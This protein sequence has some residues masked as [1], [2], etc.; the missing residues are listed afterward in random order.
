MYSHSLTHSRQ[1]SLESPYFLY[2][3]LSLLA[4][5]RFVFSVR[6]L[7]CILSI[8]T[9]TRRECF[10]KICQFLTQ[11]IATNNNNTEKTPGEMIS[12]LAFVCI[13][14]KQLKMCLPNNLYTVHI[15]IEYA[16]R[17]SFARISLQPM[18]CA[19]HTLCIDSCIA[20]DTISNVYKDRIFIQHTI[21]AISMDSEQKHLHDTLNQERSDWVLKFEREREREI[22]IFR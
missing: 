3:F 12:W 4:L 7:A 20:S 17:F 19:Y 15:I 16:L 18:F 11:Y 1:E 2:R 22:L 13:H 8:R 10:G 9:I 5:I 21:Q 14:I 6:C